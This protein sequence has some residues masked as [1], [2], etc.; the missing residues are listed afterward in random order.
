MLSKIGLAK[1]RNAGEK[2][3]GQQRALRMARDLEQVTCEERERLRV[4]LT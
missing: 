4:C 2:I 1:F 3:S